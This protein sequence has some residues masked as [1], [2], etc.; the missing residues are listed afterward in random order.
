MAGSEASAALSSVLSLA[1]VLAVLGVAFLLARRLQ[2]NGRL[3]SG[4]F[5]KGGEGPA[6]R[7]L[8]SRVLGAQTSLQLVEVDGRRFLIG[9]NRSGL[10]RLGVWP[11]P[12]PSAETA[13]SIS[14]RRA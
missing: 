14:E 9:V 11:S 2:R 6:I 5:G 12:A 1:A 4:V 8:S 7:L 13:A 3:A 10:T